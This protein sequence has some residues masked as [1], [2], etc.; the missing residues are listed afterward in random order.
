MPQ[1]KADQKFAR[2]QE[3]QRLPS[4]SALAMG[5][6][7]PVRP[8]GGIFTP[9]WYAAAGVN[10]T[11]PVFT[12]FR[13]NAQTQEARLRERASEKQTQELSDSIARDVRIA[14][15]STQTAFRR[16]G[17]AKA[18]QNQTTQ[19]LSLAQTRYK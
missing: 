3:L 15:L 2:A 16:I 10:L 13:I 12:G 7:T 1:T 8:D 9:N 4:V 5:G 18:F 6:V 14:T 17:V 11:L 19:A